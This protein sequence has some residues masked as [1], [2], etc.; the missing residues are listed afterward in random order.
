MAGRI[1]RDIV[2]L[3]QHR[4][5]L[6]ADHASILV[7][8]GVVL[9]GP[10]RVPVAPV[11]RRRL[12]LAFPT[13]R[14]VRL[15]RSGVPRQRFAPAAA[16]LELHRE[17]VIAASPCQLQS[18]RGCCCQPGARRTA[19]R[20]P[21]RVAAATERRRGKTAAAASCAGFCAKRAAPLVRSQGDPRCPRRLHG[22]SLLDRRWSCAGRRAEGSVRSS[23]RRA[24][25]RS[26]TL[27]WASAIP[28]GAA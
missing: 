8:Q 6:I 7:I 28:A 4:Q 21:G 10:V 1:A 9:C 15:P 26:P 18:E 13:R 5:Q 3:V 14:S 11:A 20:H 12:R 25:R 2:I 22:A 17:A 19:A 23:T 16:R 27:R 24:R